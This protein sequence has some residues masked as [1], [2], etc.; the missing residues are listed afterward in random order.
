MSV[1]KRSISTT[2]FPLY[3]RSNIQFDEKYFELSKLLLDNRRQI[4]KQHNWTLIWNAVFLWYTLRSFEYL[5]S[6][7]STGFPAKHLHAFLGSPSLP[8]PSMANRISLSTFSRHPV[9]SSL[10]LILLTWRIWWT[11]NNASKWQKGF[12]SAFKELNA[13]SQAVQTLQL[14]DLRSAGT[15]GPVT[16]CSLPNVSRQWSCFFFNGQVSI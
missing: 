7:L 1:S 5:L 12:N 13:T 4:H 15:L 8:L 3:Y 11:P 10:T 9:D 6:R 2:P 14:T 16:G